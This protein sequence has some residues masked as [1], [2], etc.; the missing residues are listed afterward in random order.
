MHAILYRHTSHQ[1]RSLPSFSSTFN[2]DPS[3]IA[4]RTNQSFFLN[5]DRSQVCALYI[6]THT[7][8]KIP[9]ARSQESD[10][11]SIR[12]RG[13]NHYRFSLS[14]RLDKSLIILNTYI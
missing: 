10:V 7:Q 11:L 5:I 1:F 8:K 13:K 12:L 14:Q 3:F 4:I 2:S 6:C 9:T